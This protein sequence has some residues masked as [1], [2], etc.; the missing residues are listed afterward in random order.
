MLTIA[1]NPGFALILGAIAALAL[2]KTLR[3]WLMLASAIAAIVLTFAPHLGVYHGFRQIGL[4][5][6]QFRLDELS[7][8]FGLAFGFGA[9]LVAIASGDRRNRYE[10]CAILL[11]AGGAATAVFAGDLITFVG[12]TELCSVAGAW[13]VLAAGGSASSTAGIRFLI[14]QG[15]GGLLLLCGVA[16]HLA[17]GFNIEFAP[18]PADSV[19]G[20]FLFAGLFI[21][22]GAPLAHVWFKDAVSSAS[23]VGAAALC[24]FT[25]NVALY[26]F[27]RGFAG[28]AV[29]API[30]AAMAVLG[31]LYALAEDD[32]RRAVAYSLIAQTGLALAA[33]GAGSP[34]ALA[35]ATTHA[36]TLVLVY[37]L[38][39]FA[40]GAVMLQTGTARASALG[41]LARAMPVTAFFGV[42]GC[43][44][45]AGTPHLALYASQT[46][47]LA[48]VANEGWRNISII[49]LA[50]AAATAAFA[51]VRL[52]AALFFGRPKTYAQVM[53]DV[54][55]P[56]GLILAMTLAAFFLIVMG[57]APGWLIRIAPPAPIPLDA[58]DAA[59]AGPRLELLTGA[60]LGYAAML[61]VGATGERRARDLLD[62]DA[63]YRGPAASAA[64]L[65]GAGLLWV[66]G[67]LKAAGEFALSLTGRVIAIFARASDR[68]LRVGPAGAAASLGAL[69]IL[70]ALVYVFA[71]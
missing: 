15:L 67:R 59:R 42:L 35:G 60:A 9:V 33:I 70:F 4:D 19:G 23:P 39:L 3:G 48:A 68:P 63:F 56:F 38:L 54:P 1:V 43:F 65:M 12:A 34:L 6:V 45:A 57:A 49:L 46:L 5:V 30:G 32:L 26:A 36:F 31:V 40:I 61:L 28:E 55:A 53:S 14:W 11:L 2:P 18:L 29:L 51:A 41:G 52:P 24:A 21:K 58:F 17:E 16:F 27:A 10:D 22:V 25:S 47:S 50:A 44:A 71:T 8:T 64:R 13:I 37:S 7:R 69:L 20:G 62:V 66:Y